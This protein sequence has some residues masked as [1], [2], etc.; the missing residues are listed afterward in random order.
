MTKTQ[1][2]IVTKVDSRFTTFASALIEYAK[3]DAIFAESLADSI[4]QLPWYRTGISYKE[5]TASEFLTIENQQEAVVNTNWL[6]QSLPETKQ[7]T[8]TT[9][10]LSS[11]ANQYESPNNLAIGIIGIM[12]MGPTLG[13]LEK[14][15][16]KKRSHLQIVIEDKL[17]KSLSKIKLAELTQ[18]LSMQ[19]MASELKLSKGNAYSLHPDSAQWCLEES[20]TKIFVDSKENI[21]EISK[22]A[23]NDNLSFFKEKTRAGWVIAISPSVNDSLIDDSDAKKCD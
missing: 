8:G 7:Q 23:E 13:I 3:T 18:K 4:Q 15:K 20:A 2:I 1:N 10:L 9:E 21:Q 14:T 6:L 19:L 11:W 17:Y 12:I 5:N 16:K 22:V